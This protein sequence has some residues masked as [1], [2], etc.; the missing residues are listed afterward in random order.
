VFF[1]CFYSFLCVATVNII[2]SNRLLDILNQFLR[3][4]SPHHRMDVAVAE[5][6]SRT[7]DAATRKIGIAMDPEVPLQDPVL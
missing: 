1:F 5:A 3:P 6:M 2:I 4:G 7:A